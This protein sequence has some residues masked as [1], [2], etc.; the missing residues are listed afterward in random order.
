M[1]TTP[2]SGFGPTDSLPMPQG[3]RDSAA[4]GDLFGD[5]LRG[6]VSQFDPTA[7]AADTYVRADKPVR[8]EPADRP[9]PASS[10][11][12]DGNSAQNQDAGSTQANDD[13]KP[14]AG[15]NQPSSARSKDKH[16]D[17]NE[18]GG[19]G[20]DDAA[21]SD[22]VA[23]DD[24]SCETRGIANA[25]Q[26]VTNSV[27]QAILAV[28]AQDTPAAPGEVAAAA[29]AAAHDIAPVTAALLPPAPAAADATPETVTEPDSL[30]ANFDVPPPAQD[31]TQ[32]AA[33]AP[34]QADAGRKNGGPLPAETTVTNDANTMISRPQATLAPVH[35]AQ[36]AASDADAGDGD[37]DDTTLAGSS[38][39]LE[40][41]PDLVGDAENAFRP[42]RAN[43]PRF[44]PL[45][46]PLADDG[47]RTWKA[48]TDGANWQPQASVQ[49]M[50]GAGQ[51]PAGN[52]GIQP[53]A[54]VQHL[55]NVA[56]ADSNSAPTS[57]TFDQV[58]IHISKAVADGLDKISIQLKP[59]SLGRID[60]QLQVGHDG[61]VNAMIAAQ[62]QDTLDLLQ[63]DARSLERA[64]Q[65]AGLRADSGSL[66]FNLS[67]QQQDNRPSGFAAATPASMNGV[68]A[69]EETLPLSSAAIARDYAAA[70]GGVDIRV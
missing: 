17:D 34:E 23:A 24:C 56:R 45:I 61:R 26:N 31:D 48:P 19:G 39:D 33:A 58:A 16:G 37:A 49:N 38:D 35:P 32:F 3:A 70:R 9:Q 54:Q 64:L 11:R 15:D 42:Q 59:E 13:A 41:A 18:T 25:I 62:R 8:S 10:S 14:A 63:R 53:G 50:Q 68:G 66:N 27:A 57:P 12:S 30:P 43:A 65:D 2:I 47:T 51:A 7:Q 67:G 21:G 22:D 46:D 6:Q 40:A 69:G 52:L 5:L 29:T 20:A 1:N 28:L 60:V 4:N 36:I 55:A 44:N